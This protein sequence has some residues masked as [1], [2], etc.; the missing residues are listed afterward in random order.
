MDIKLGFHHRF[1]RICVANRQ[2]ANECVARRLEGLIAV[3]VGS[4]AL[5]S[6]RRLDVPFRG[7]RALV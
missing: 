4:S 1:P 7:C 2:R 6:G 3:T 5:L